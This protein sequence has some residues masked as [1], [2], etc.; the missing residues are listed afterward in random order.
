MSSAGSSPLARGLR[1][2]CFRPSPRRRIIPARAGFTIEAREYS[3]GREDHPRSRGVYIDDMGM[4]Y[5]I[6]GSSPLARGLPSAIMISASGSGII[7]ARAGFTGEVSESIFRSS[8]HPRSRGVY[9]LPVR[10]GPR[11]DG[12]SPLAR[13]LRLRDLDLD[14]RVRI[15]PARAGFTILRGTSLPPHRDHPRSRGVYRGVRARDRGRWGSSPLARGL[16][17]QYLEQSP[18][19]RII[20]ARAGFTTT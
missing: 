20:P 5:A 15:I 12:S 11:L 17:E 8:D 14:S 3:P 13:G 9:P 4:F 19:D 18:R 2:E 7:P 1:G 10:L 6:R 16:P